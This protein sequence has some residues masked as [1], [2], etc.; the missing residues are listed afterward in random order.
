MSGATKHELTVIDPR[1]LL[2]HPLNAWLYG[3]EPEPEFVE[4]VR[5]HGVLTPIL[6]AQ[7]RTIISGHRR[8]QAA[9]IAGV[10][11]VPIDIYPKEL[12]DLE[13]RRLLI[14][15]N[16]QRKKTVEQC[17]REYA[18]LK[19]VE[20]LL[21]KQRQQKHGGTAPGRGST[22]TQENT[23][24]SDRGKARDRAASKLGMS[25]P[26]AE[27][28]LNVVNAIDQAEAAG[29]TAKAA[30]LRHKLENESVSAA[31]RAATEDTKRVMRAETAFEPAP[32]LDET[33]T[34]IPR[35]LKHVF[36]SRG[37]F[38]AMLALL[39]KVSRGAR[40]LSELPGGARI[41]AAELKI[42]I[43]NVRR[44]LRFSRPHAVCPYCKANGQPCEACKKTG[45][46]TESILDQAPKAPA[47]EPTTIGAL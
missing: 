11:V 2:S 22:N 20:E 37:D 36:I 3:T 28:A 29:D 17:G 12:D 25:G 16:L 6:I 47:G 1:K 34:P 7:S 33:G 26:T 46:V 14:V 31:H 9:I 43:E 19:S 45:W 15:H 35:R 39:A 27:K 23:S 18:E 42:L 32:E 40:K 41:R 24:A 4:S 38:D 44:E 5:K 21:A 10:G 30:D 13:L 8:C